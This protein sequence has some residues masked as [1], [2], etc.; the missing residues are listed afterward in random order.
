MPKQLIRGDIDKHVQSQ[1]TDHEGD[2]NSS[3]DPEAAHVC[4]DIA[5]ISATL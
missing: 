3:G 4:Q 2:G 5:N 1:N